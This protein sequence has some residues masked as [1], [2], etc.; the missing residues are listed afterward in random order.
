[1]KLEV[2]CAWCGSPFLKE[3]KE[4]N[5]ASK[6]GRNH[7]CKLAHAAAHK[8]TLDESREGARVRCAAQVGDK[9]PNWKGGVSGS[10][11]VLRSRAR[12][13][14]RWKARKLVERAILSGHLIRPK[15]CA[16][17]GTEAF[18]EAHHEDYSKPFAV[19]WLCAGC[20]D[21]RDAV[22]RSEGRL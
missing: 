14:E 19:E 22:M 4:V 8:N 2:L 10:E 12:R 20:H 9:N 17:C 3:A 11:S 15:H 21:G 6:L 7:F 5:R 1:M 13:P 18:C 16:A